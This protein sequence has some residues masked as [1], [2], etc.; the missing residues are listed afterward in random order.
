MPQLYQI[1]TLTD[2][3]T[4]YY[5]EQV[6]LSGQDYLLT[7]NWNTY[8]EFWTL[9]LASADGTPIVYGRTLV[10]GLDLLECIPLPAS[11]SRPRPPGPLF[12]FQSGGAPDRPRLNSLGV[13]GSHGLYYFDPRP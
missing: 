2:G 7:L 8:G 3:Q 6:S 9:D 1:Q 5:S 12:V 13:G 10:L 4:P 11:A